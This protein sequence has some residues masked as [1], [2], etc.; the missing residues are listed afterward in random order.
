M[1]GRM[2]VYIYYI[3]SAG[4]FISLQLGSPCQG[5]RYGTEEK[6]GGT[7]R[8]S[9]TKSHPPPA[10][11]LSSRQPGEPPCWTSSLAFGIIGHHPRDGNASIVYRQSLA[12]LK[13]VLSVMAGK[14]DAV[15]YMLHTTLRQK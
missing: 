8:P 9:H 10:G 4:N 3:T 11:S 2:V 12:R 5:N 14:D 13:K 15:S 1:T 6:A 7:A